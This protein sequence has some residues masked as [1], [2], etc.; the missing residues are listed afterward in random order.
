MGTVAV[1]RLYNYIFSLIEKSWVIYYG[2]VGLADITGEDYSVVLSILSDIH[3]YDC[4]AEHVTRFIMAALNTATDSDTTQIFHGEK[5]RFDCLGIFHSVKRYFR[6]RSA[7]SLR[8]MALC[9]I[10]SVFLLQLG[11]IEE[12]NLGDISRRLGTIYLALVTIPYQSRQKSAMVK[13]GMGQE[14]GIN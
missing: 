1:G 11:S 2:A 7:A 9:L 5:M 8:F 14:N 12:D 3:T 6:I 13:M 4:R 10:C